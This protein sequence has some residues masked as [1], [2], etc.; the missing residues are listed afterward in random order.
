[1]ASRDRW[2]EWLLQR[3]HGGDAG[4]HQAI[5]DELAVVRARVLEHA[6]LQLG[7]VVLDVGAGDGLIGFGALEKVGPSGEV[8]FSDVSP[9]LVDVCR[10]I[11]L[12]LSVADR[13]RF[14][15]ADAADLAPIGDA[16]VDAVTTRSVLIYVHNKTR[17]FAEFLRVLSPGGWISIHEPINRLMC[18]EPPGE[19]LS[20]EVGPVR[21]LADKVRAAA[22]ENSEAESTLM[23]FDERDLVAFA[24]AAGFREVHLE[25][26]R[27]IASHL[28]PMGWDAFLASSGNPLA[29]S[30]GEM[31]E[32]ALTQS[33]QARFQ[34]HLR[35]LVESGVQVRRLA[36][37]DLWAQ[38]PG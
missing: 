33:E 24:E 15:V 32:R 25:L 8:T 28:A 30:N 17:A 19:F 7:S 4:R 5:L 18:P 36:L 6:A 1:M 10:T 35:P 9:D 22:E 38:R 14:V 21:D 13:C 11:A 26:R 27:Q 37:A 23:D 29:P 20:Y 16:S 3:R 31:I 34:A 2:A 12:Q